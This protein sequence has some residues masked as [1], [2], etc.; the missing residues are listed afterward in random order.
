MHA[1]GDLG[2]NRGLDDL[3][4][5]LRN[6]DAFLALFA[7]LDLRPAANGKMAPAGGIGIDNALTAADDAAGWEIGAGQNF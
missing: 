5:N 1:F 2:D 6:D 4:R 3:I 7:G